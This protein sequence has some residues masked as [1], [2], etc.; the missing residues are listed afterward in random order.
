MRFS[1]YFKLNKSQSELDFVDIPLHTDILLYIDPYA[2]SK[3]E[4]LFSEECNAIL[5]NFFQGI[6]DDIK[7]GNNIRAKYNLSMLGE[8][9][10]THLGMSKGKPLG[11]GVSGIQSL[12]LFESLSQSE[13]VKTGFLKDL[14]ECELVIPGISWDKISDIVTNVIKLKLIEYTEEQCKTYN[15]PTKKIPSGRFW[16]PVTGRWNERYA[17]LPVYAGRRILLV[18]KA[19][20]R[21]SLAFNHQKY[22]NHFVLNYL[23]EEHLNAGSALVMLLKNGDKKVYKKDL[24]EK[25]EYKLTKK[26]LYEFSSEH[27]EVLKNYVKSLPTTIQPISNQEIEKKQNDPKDSTTGNLLETLTQ[28]KPGTENADDYH[29]HMVGVLEYIFYPNLIIPQKEVRIHE[30]RKRIDITYQNA[31]KTGFFEYLVNH[32]PCP[33]ILCECKNYIEDPKN[34]E[35]DQIAGRFSPRRGQFGIL[36]CRKVDNKDLMRKRCRDIADDGRGYVL[37]LDDED[38]ARLLKYKNENNEEAINNFLIEKYKELVM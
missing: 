3:R 27:P 31:A 18:P 10:D 12:D 16:N 4:D 8:P 33:F 1:K 35:L 34:P 26:F 14:S 28:I 24:K 19:I 37:V 2:L 30:G 32:V 38:I 21:Y 17:N 11:K 7:N 9:N 15:I 36:L 20:V 29:N 25:E 6:I 23:Q 5:I 13:A 22:Y